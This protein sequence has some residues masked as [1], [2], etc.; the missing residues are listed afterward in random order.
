M[1][2]EVCESWWIKEG[3]SGNDIREEHRAGSSKGTR[4]MAEPEIDK[5]YGHISPRELFSQQGFA[6]PWTAARQASLSFTISLSLLK[7]MS[8]E[9]VMT[10]N[11]L[12]LCSPLLLPPSIFPTSWSFP[13]SQF[14]AS[15]CQS[16]GASAS[17]HP[18]N[19]QGWF[20]LGLTGWI[21]LL[22]N[23]LS[24]VFIS[25]TTQKHQFFSA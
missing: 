18:M 25:T 5:C 15:G 7:L 3:L 11:H 6:T 24:R 20:P 1:L 10:S 4:L 9:S 17:V 19:I 14:F 13:V 23:G 2:K 12:T 22:S 8:V 21:S 16:I